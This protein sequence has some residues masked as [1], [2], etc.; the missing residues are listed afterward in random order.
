VCQPE[1]V[2]VRATPIPDVLAFG[3]EK[4][5]KQVRKYTGEPYI[6]HPL[7][8]ASIV[9]EYLPAYPVE[10]HDV[11][12]KV[13]VLHDVMEDQGVTYEE[14]EQ[15]FGTQVADGVLLLSDLDGGNRDERNARTL[16]RLAGAPSWV[17]TVKCGDLISNTKSI[18]QHDIGFAVPY[19]REKRRLL[20]VMHDA[21][22]E[23]HARAVKLAICPLCKGRGFTL[24]LAGV[25]A[26]RCT[27]EKYN[28]R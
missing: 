5:A 10:L 2:I 25:K 20:A 12:V 13:A 22:P 26:C 21:H 11:M 6:A 4:H 8:V 27:K 16:E 24:S 14:L 7:E 18:V 17:Q 15:R 3:I 19:L 1:A 9:A 28:G 23:I